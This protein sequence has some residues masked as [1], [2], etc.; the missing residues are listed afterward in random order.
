LKA[1]KILAQNGFAEGLELKLY[2]WDYAEWDYRQ[3]AKDLEVDRYV[4][5]L[6]YENNVLQ[7]YEEAYCLILPSLG[8]GLSNVL[9]EGMAMK[10]P[11][12]ASKVSGTTEVL[13]HEKNGLLIPP[14]SPEALARAMELVLVQPNLAATWGN[15]ARQKAQGHYS[16]NAVARKYADLYELLVNQEARH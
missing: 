12:I 7:V 2:G 1:V 6:P 3:M 15:R 14:G 11:V 8:E 10:L 16:L 9:L 13:E 5:F 4:R